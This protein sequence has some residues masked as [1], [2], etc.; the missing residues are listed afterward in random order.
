MV[1]GQWTSQCREPQPAMER[2]ELGEKNMETAAEG[3]AR[4]SKV[5]ISEIT[6]PPRTRENRA[7]CDLPALPPAAP[8]DSPPRCCSLC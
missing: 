6:L 2:D 1:S 5:P 8:E 4:P 7:A 3:L